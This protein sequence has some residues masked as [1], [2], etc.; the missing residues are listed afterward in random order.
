MSSSGWGEEAV[1]LTQTPLDAIVVVS[2]P[3]VLAAKRA[4]ITVPVIMAAS[5][6]PPAV[7]WAPFLARADQVIE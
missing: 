6:D 3:A 5:A 4:T 1:S 2:T 7:A